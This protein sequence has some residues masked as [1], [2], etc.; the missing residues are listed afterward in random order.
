MTTEVIFW[1]QVMSIV[2]FVGTAFFLYRLLSEQK[3]ATI[4]LLRETISALKDQLIEAR[5]ITPDV[6]A[7]T[8]AARAKLLEAELERVSKDNGATKQEVTEVAE[9]LNSARAEIEMLAKQVEIAHDL[10]EDFSCPFCGLPMTV[11]NLYSDSVEHKGREIDIE[12]EYVQYECGY[13]VRDGK[14]ESEC[15]GT[16]PFRVPCRMG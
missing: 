3:D 8:L 7:Q 4:Q 6:L 13:A 2:T 15:P 16:K 5:R 11:R 14:P 1:V 9:K 10:L 12:H